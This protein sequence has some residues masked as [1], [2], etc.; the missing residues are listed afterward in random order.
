MVLPS[1]TAAPGRSRPSRR[2]ASRAG[3]NTIRTSY[4][5]ASSSEWRLRGPLSTSRRSSWLMSRPA[6]SIRGPVSRSWRFFSSSTRSQESLS[7]WSPTSR[8]SRPTPG[9]CSSLRTAGCCGMRRLSGQ[10]QR[11]RNCVSARQTKRGSRSMNLLVNVRIALRALRVNRLRSALTMLGII[12]GV[13]AVIAMVAVGSG[14]TAQIQEQI[15][16]IGSNVLIVLSG[17]TTSGGIRLGH[18]SLLTL[19]EEDAKAIALECPAVALAASSVR[20]TAQAIF[21][22]TNW[23]TVI[24]GVTPE[25]LQIRDFTVQSGRP[26]TWQ[27]V[28]GATKVALVGHTVVENLFGGTDPVGQIIRIKK[29]PFT[30]LGILS[31]KG[32]SAFGQDQDDIILLPISTAKRKVL[33]V[34]QANARSVGAIVVQARGPTMI[35]EAEEQVIALLRQRHRLQPEQ[36][37]DF[38]VRNLVEIFGAQEQ[39]GSEE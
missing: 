6:T 19:T 27:D 13:A 18:G 36:D 25:Y 39:A 23:S 2:S 3:K 10:E 28:D 31:A 22:N 38:T 15:R 29:V 20:G 5:A 4:R 9:A 26:F 16:S 14:A 11:F 32:Q 7:S 37:D 21:G 24:Q 34:S 30:V 17:S 1:A 8:T 12:I 35:Q 33:G